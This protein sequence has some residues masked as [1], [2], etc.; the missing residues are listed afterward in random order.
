MKSPPEPFPWGAVL[1]FC[2]GRLRLPPDTVWA[3]TLP[4]LALLAGGGTGRDS[5]SR[6]DLMALLEAYPDEGVG[7]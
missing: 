6:R 3:L 5:P 4:E 1:A 7:R 2:F